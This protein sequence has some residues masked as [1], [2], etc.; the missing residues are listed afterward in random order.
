ME[1]NGINLNISSE[2]R[3]I[4]N[5]E[6][7]NILNEK[8]EKIKEMINYNFV[9]FKGGAIGILFHI[10][11]INTVQSFISIFQKKQKSKFLFIKIKI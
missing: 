2:K 7:E 11:D 3:K 5:K 6:E 10:N 4:Y 8:Q 9:D 1:K